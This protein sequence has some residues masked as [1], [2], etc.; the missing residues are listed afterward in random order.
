VGR[1]SRSFVVRIIRTTR[2]GQHV[3]CIALIALQLNAGGAPAKDLVGVYEDAL[4]NDP[5]L[6]AADANRLASRESRPQAVAA[7]LPQVQGSAAYTREH[8]SGNQDQLQVTPDYQLY[9]VPLP[10]T[11]STTGRQWAL[12]ARQNLFSWANWVRVKQANKQVAQA[13]TNYAAA[14]Q[15]LI[16]RVARAYFNVLTAVDTLGAQQASLQAFEAQFDQANQ[17]YSVGVVASAD[18][19]E[20]R[21]ARDTASA[22][23]IAAKR[24]LTL[25]EDRLQEI[26]GEQYDALN[27]PT[28]DPPLNE[29]S[30]ADETSWVNL[31]LEQNPALVA[32]R[33]AAEIARDN[34]SIARSDHFPSVDVLA[35]RS[36]ERDS[37]DYFYGRDTVQGFGSKINDRQISLQVTI[38]LFSGGLTQSR[39]RQSQYLWIAAKS[40]LTQASRVAERQTRDAY[41]GVISGIARVRA[42]RQASNSSATALQATEAGYASGSRTAL[43]VL[44]ARHT[45]VQT[46]TDY[47]ASRYDYL[48][49]RIELL[50]AAGTLERAELASINQLLTAS[51]S[52]EQSA[53]HN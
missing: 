41:L 39:V 35:G 37:G 46:Q 28:G 30:P 33:L 34:V 53:P 12:T 23:V 4:R 13:E 22:A 24:T 26:T 52:L 3:W 48:L 6:H 9:V 8:N 47:A 18:V 43:D 14:Q 2:H 31:S 25:M 19:E 44:N 42:L 50:L 20:S 27:K 10:Y 32:S 40:Q 38:P 16:F 17:K 7:L 5:Q 15:D 51:A 36:Y 45:L 49:S 21:A 11:G 29:P 1:A